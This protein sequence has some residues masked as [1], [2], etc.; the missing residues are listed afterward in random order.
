MNR[1]SFWLATLVAAVFGLMT[2][3]SAQTPDL[4]YKFNETSGTAAAN[5][6]TVG[7]A[8]GT[9]N[10]APNWLSPGRIGTGMV[11]IDPGANTQ[12]PTPTMT[13]GY[14]PSANLTGDFTLEVWIRTTYGGTGEFFGPATL[15]NF[16]HWFTTSRSEFCL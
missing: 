16:F 6:G 2:G 12:D 5:D 8:N 11:N 15:T 13:T 4:Y 14:D 9:F 3:L 10:A 1:G 7:P